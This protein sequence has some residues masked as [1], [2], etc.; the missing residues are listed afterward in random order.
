M[1]V[2]LKLF[3]SMHPSDALYI[4]DNAHLRVLFINNFSKSL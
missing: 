1:C 2:I 4:S 3:T